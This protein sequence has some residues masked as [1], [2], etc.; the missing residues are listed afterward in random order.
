MLVRLACAALFPAAICV[1]LPAHAGEPEDV[2]AGIYAAYPWEDLPPG[3]HGAWYVDIAAAWGGGG[4]DA[5]K[6]FLLG[7]AGG[8]TNVETEVVA[9]GGYES[10]VRTVLSGPDGAVHR[11]NFG[12]IGDDDEDDRWRVM[13]VFTD[14]GK[15]LS[16]VLAG[17]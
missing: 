7:T 4:A 17:R 13:E 14:D 5:G 11:L 3:G 2:V 1:Q 9:S 16:E 12:L 8:F 15:Y 10:R 6:A